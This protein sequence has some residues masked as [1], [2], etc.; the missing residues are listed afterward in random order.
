M[1][2]YQP[3]PNNPTSVIALAL[4]SFF[5]FLLLSYYSNN[6]DAIERQFSTINTQ[7]KFNIADFKIS[8]EKTQRIWKDVVLKNDYRTKIFSEAAVRFVKDAVIKQ[9]V[10]V[11]RVESKKDDKDNSDDMASWVKAVNINEMPSL[12]A[13][14]NAVFDTSIGETQSISDTLTN[15]INSLGSFLGTPV[16]FIHDI[17]FEVIIDFIL[18]ELLVSMTPKGAKLFDRGDYGTD[19]KRSLQTRLKKGTQPSKKLT[20][21][22]LSTE[23]KT[24]F[25]NTAYRKGLSKTYTIQQ[26]KLQFRKK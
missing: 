6:K 15:L 2:N 14:L 19:T 11:N 4:W 3:S 20:F 13:S 10:D 7:N 18:D 17:I 26:T 9:K 12:I 25:L 8:T 5:E 24:K 23:M 22:R 16:D 21:A 1:V